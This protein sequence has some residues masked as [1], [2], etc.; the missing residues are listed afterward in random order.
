MQSVPDRRPGVKGYVSGEQGYAK[1]VE[2]NAPELA[3]GTDIIGFSD[4]LNDHL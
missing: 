4:R 3:A 1:K 2:Y